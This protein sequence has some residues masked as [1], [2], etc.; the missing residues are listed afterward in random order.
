MLKG[1]GEDPKTVQES[2][3]HAN[4]HITMDLYAQAIPEAIRSAQAKVVESIGTELIGPLL[5]PDS[6]VSAVSC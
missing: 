5:V 6:T 4:F 1:N 2:L 3:R